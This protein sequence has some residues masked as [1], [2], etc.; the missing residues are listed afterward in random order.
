M[1]ARFLAGLLALALVSA[2]R[3]A[4]AAD[5][6]LLPWSTHHAS[7]RRDLERGQPLV[8][9]VVVPLCHNAQIDCGSAAAGKPGSLKTNLYW[10]AIFGARRFLDR[11]GSGW[12][13]LEVSSD[14]EP[15]VLERVVYRRKVSP[16]PWRIAR[17][18]PIE[19]IVVL[20][21]VHGDAIDSAVG[22]LWSTASA[23]ATISFMDAGR[24]RRLPVHVVGYTG[25]NRMMDGLRL[26]EVSAPSR[27]AV[28]S[29]VLACYSESYF[30]EALK[31]VGSRPLVMTRALMAPEGYVLDAV[32]RGLAENDS[33]R[34][35]RQRAVAAYAKWQKL[36]P[37]AAST[38]FAK[39]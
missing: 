30:S 4:P 14:P 3:A 10:G 31:R 37:G 29:F 13:R 21:A 5:S 25:H 36:S 27:T 7:V 2:P 8:V 24:A 34:G 17:D 11:R 12:Q 39:R 19:Q 22:K 26:P 20:E 28:P 33:E 18:R 32:L 35:L 1:T 9:R 16:K 38:I 6:T 23:G 15:G